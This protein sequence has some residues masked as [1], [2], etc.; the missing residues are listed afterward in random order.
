MDF[1]R[2][3]QREQWNSAK[4][5]KEILKHRFG[6]SDLLPFWVADM[7]FPSPPAVSRILRERADHQVYGYP[8]S[9]RSF[10]K[11]WQSW[12]QNRHNWDVPL[13]DAVFIPGIVTAMSLGVSLY[14]EPGDAVLLQEPVYQPFRRMIEKNKRIIPG[15][16]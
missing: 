3:I 12:T 16:P 6:H 8:A 1:D 9:N 2:L 15:L 5:D 4:W 11:A 13:T 14:S 10:L 7:D